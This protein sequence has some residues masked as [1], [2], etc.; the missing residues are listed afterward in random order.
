MAD[1]LRTK[2]PVVHN[3]SG[4]VFADLGLPDAAE[5]DE[6]VRLA[7]MVN[8]EIRRQGLRQ[9]AASERLSINQAEVSRLAHYKLSGFSERRLMGFLNAMGREVEIIVKPA[10]GRPAQTT[11]RELEKA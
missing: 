2:T 6:K 8:Q 4:N 7:T 1:D 10:Q 9:V 11:I 3:G 5:Q